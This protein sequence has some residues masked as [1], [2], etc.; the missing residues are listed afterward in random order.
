MP[1]SYIY[2]CDRC[3]Y[4][5]NSIGEYLYVLNDKGERIKCYH[6]L[7]SSQ[8]TQILGEDPSIEEVRART[9]KLTYCICLECL[10]HFHL[11]LGG[12]IHNPILSHLDQQI[13]S[14]RRSKLTR[15]ELKQEDEQWKAELVQALKE[16]SETRSAEKPCPFDP[17]NDDLQKDKREC[18]RCK[19]TNVRTRAELT[20]GSCPRCRIGIIRKWWTGGIT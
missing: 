10:K 14:D 11:D 3:R 4:S 13:R 2:K 18:P 20:F 12:Y 19:S 7:E 16:L 1:L 5:L 9:G 15:E 6:P 8:V 17:N